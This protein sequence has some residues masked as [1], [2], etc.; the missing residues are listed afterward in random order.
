MKNFDKYYDFIKD[1]ETKNTVRKIADKAMYVNKNYTSA[2]T[3]FINPF[4]AEL[5]MPIIKNFS[6]KHEL[7]PS[8]EQGERKVFILYPDYIE[9]I[10][11]DDYI[12]TIRIMN[13]SKFKKL[14]HKD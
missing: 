8:F 11:K 12:T 14:S 2:I 7:F 13:K 5:C 4:V 3:E 1:E 9:E 6:I 10:N